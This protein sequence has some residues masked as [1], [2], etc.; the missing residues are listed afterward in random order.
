ME[1]KSDQTRI[2]NGHKSHPMLAPIVGQCF[3]PTHTWRKSNC[4]DDLN[5]AT[6][7]CQV[8]NTAVLCASA[9][10]AVLLGG[11]KWIPL[12][13]SLYSAP[14]AMRSLFSDFFRRFICGSIR[15]LAAAMAIQLSRHIFKD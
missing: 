13:T 1:P 10:H 3:L 2:A 6:F 8:R 14:S 11:Y 5:A 12:Q 9:S 15:R 7:N 4:A